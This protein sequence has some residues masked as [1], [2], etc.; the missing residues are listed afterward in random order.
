ML[1]SPGLD[2]VAVFSSEQDDVLKY[3]AKQPRPFRM[4]ADPVTY[5]SGFFCETVIFWKDEGDDV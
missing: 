3:I 4:V 2:I 1:S 5:T